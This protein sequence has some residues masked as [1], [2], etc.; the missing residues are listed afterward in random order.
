LRMCTSKS[1]RGISQKHTTLPRYASLLESGN[2]GFFA[3]TWRARDRAGFGRAFSTPLRRMR[4]NKRYRSFRFDRERPTKC[5][6]FCG[7]YRCTFISQR[8]SHLGRTGAKDG[9]GGGHDARRDFLGE[10]VARRPGLHISA[11]ILG[12]MLDS[13]TATPAVFFNTRLH[14]L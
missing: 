10:V 14:T 7:T 13:A 1:P 3:N 11:R 8:L 2:A 5:V 4:R 6:K 12:G 9:I